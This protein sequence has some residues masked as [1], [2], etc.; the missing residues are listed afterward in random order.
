MSCIVIRLHVINLSQAELRADEFR[1][2]D[3]G[4]DDNEGEAATTASASEASSLTPINALTTAD[5]PV[6]AKKGLVGVLELLREKS[7]K[8]RIDSALKP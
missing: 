4:D 7:L 1:S 2:S 8:Q 6:R 5:I 3:L